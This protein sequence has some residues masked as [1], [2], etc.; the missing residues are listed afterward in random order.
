VSTR[1]EL[2]AR[3]LWQT[4]ADPF[5][6]NEWVA[7]TKHIRAADRCWPHVGTALHHRWGLWPMRVR[8][9]TVVTHCDPPSRLDLDARARP[10]AVVEVSIRLCGTADGTLVTLRETIVAGVAA[11]VPRIA[12][13]IQR[14][15][16]RRSL[17]CLVRLTAAR[18]R[19]NPR[20]VP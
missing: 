20:A 16:N 10:I 6:F 18:A 1:T 19:R 11:H 13:A 17:D 12:A 15:R 14:R 7:G 4:L 2:P 8:D 5:S 3:A 9:R